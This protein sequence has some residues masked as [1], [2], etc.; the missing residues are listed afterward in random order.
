MSTTRYYRATCGSLYRVRQVPATRQLGA[1]TMQARHSPSA[2]EFS[3]EYPTTT[4]EVARLVSVGS[5]FE[6]PCPSQEIPG[7]PPTPDQSLPR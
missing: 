5:F 1:H 7:G 3:P 4:A 6:V 2:V